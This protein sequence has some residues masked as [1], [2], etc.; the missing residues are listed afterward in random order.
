M[1]FRYKGL[2][3]SLLYS[4]LPKENYD[5]PIM[6]GKTKLINLPAII[7]PFNKLA[8]LFAKDKVI[9]NLELFI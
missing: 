2:S 3:S 9:P 7:A 1:Y 4:K 5:P 6:F 8:L